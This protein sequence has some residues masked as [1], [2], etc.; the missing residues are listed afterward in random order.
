MTNELTNLTRFRREE[1][2]VFLNSGQVPG[3]QSVDFGNELNAVPVSFIGLNY[4]NLAP[5]GP[6]ESRVKVERL[7]IDGTDH[8][9][10]FTGNSGFNLYVI[11]DKADPQDNYG[12]TSGYIVGYTTKC[13]L[14]Q[15]PRTEI[16]IV[17]FGNVG[18]IPSGESNETSGQF[19]IIPST[20]TSYNLK[21][22]GPGSVS[23]SLNNDLTLNR[24]LSYDV[25][26]SIDRKA[27][28]ALGDRYPISV[29]MNYPIDVNI[30]FSYELADYSGYTTRNF[31]GNPKT[32]NF[33]LD[34]KDFTTDEVIQNF[35]FT[36]VQLVSESYSTD[37]D[38]NVS[39]NARYRVLLVR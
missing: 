6:Q 36:G 33:K 8:F 34:I 26:M 28:Y 27:I 10:P 31:P 32:G 5:N 24:L 16:D 4:V 21:I 1:Q 30:G 7:V 37:T 23:L 29:Q 19:L 22:P 12:V 20:T 3:I 25:S 2:L 14:G 18:R 39:I 38:S 15:I 13:S 11:K 17:G 35:R 9:Q